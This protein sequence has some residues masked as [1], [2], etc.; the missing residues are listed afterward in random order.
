MQEEMQIGDAPRRERRTHTVRERELEAEVTRQRDAL[1][2]ALD[3]LAWCTGYLDGSSAHATPHHVWAAYHVVR[4]SMGLAS[5]D[6]FERN[7]VVA[8]DPDED[9]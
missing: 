8:S 5:V 1:G 6:S 2:H 9:D 7:H 4:A 3:A